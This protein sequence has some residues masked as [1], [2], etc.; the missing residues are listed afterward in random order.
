MKLK[1]LLIAALI[2][3]GSYYPAANAQSL[4]LTAFVTP[5]TAGNTVW[6]D[7]YADGR[8][9]AR[10]FSDNTFSTVVEFNAL[11]G[12]QYEWW[13]EDHYLYLRPAFSPFAPT[14]FY[15]CPPVGTN[16]TL[17][18]TPLV[19]A[20]IG[21]LGLDTIGPNYTYL[22]VTRGLVIFNNNTLRLG[23]VRFRMVGF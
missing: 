20:Q 8:I 7:R 2:G 23:Q 1:S 15:L 19:N 5:V 17:M 3:A 9:Y 4:S 6:I 21:A 11:G 18:A 13:L 14:R 22:G 10:G 16:V 12:L